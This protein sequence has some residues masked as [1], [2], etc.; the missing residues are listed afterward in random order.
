MSEEHKY[1]KIARKAIE[2]YIR[3]N[4]ILILKDE[5][6]NS[7]LKER[8]GTFVS[9]KK[10]G[11]LRGCIGTVRPVQD[12]LAS[13]IINNAISTA[14]RDPRFRPVQAEE[15][16]ALEISVDVMGEPEKIDTPEELDVKEY[17]VIVKNGSRSGL[18]LPDLEGVD[19]VEKQINIARRKAGI[20][21]NE[22]I[23]LYR[24]KVNRYE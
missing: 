22:D 13:E 18:L 21:S 23:E 10:Q 2:K 17:G 1:V 14:T 24:F 20:G 11:N 19:T 9:L 16:N 6:L 3:E 12:N 7:E 15:I 4:E 8:A 5:E